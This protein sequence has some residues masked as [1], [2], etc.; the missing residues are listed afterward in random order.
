MV[1]LSL[2]TTS[3]MHSKPRTTK[4]NG[5]KGAMVHDLPVETYS[6]P[7]K[8]SDLINHSHQLV[9]QQCIRKRISAW[10][11]QGP[12]RQQMLQPG[13]SSQGANSAE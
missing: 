4:W 2:L 5:P 8:H 9:L 13:E 11:H 10:D 6:P 3:T 1:Q 12:H 7:D